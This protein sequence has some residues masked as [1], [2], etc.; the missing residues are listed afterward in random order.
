MALVPFPAT[1]AAA[2]LA[3][4]GLE[5]EIRPICGLWKTAH[6]SEDGEALTQF[7]PQKSQPWIGDE[8][9]AGW[10]ALYTTARHEKRVAQHLS[11]RD[12]E[13]FLPL[14]RTQRKWSDG[15]RVTLDLPLF[16]GYLFVNI[17]RAE[18]GRVL[19]VPGALAVVTG[20]G[21][22]PAVLPETTI[23]TLRL[24][25]ESRTAEPHPL[26]EAG[27]RARIC[28]GVFAGMQGVVLRS[29]NHCRVVLTIEQI[30]RSFS[31]ELG[32]DDLELLSSDEMEAP[33]PICAGAR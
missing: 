1:A 19:D 30:M 3:R 33:E 32:L 4:I 16:P 7:E 27:Q 8:R 29:K 24:G 25:L 10:F 11:Q 13:H 17:D 18:R 6:P 9:S 12:I 31:V 15:S 22:K 23:S 20:T 28:N 26:P 14:Y 2:A 5:S 21:G